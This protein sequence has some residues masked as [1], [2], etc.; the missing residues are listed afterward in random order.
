MY[1][2]YVDESGDTATSQEKGSKTLVLTGCIMQ[3]NDKLP[4]ETKLREIKNH[5]YFN[6]DVEIKSN[7]LRYANPDIADKESPITDLSCF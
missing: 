7:F 3:E 6:P 1:L 4:I 5:Y 2:M